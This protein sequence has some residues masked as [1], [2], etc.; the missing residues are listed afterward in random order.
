M[1]GS[2]ETPAMGSIKRFAIKQK[3]AH[4][5]KQNRLPAQLADAHGTEG[6]PVGTRGT[7]HSVINIFAEIRCIFK[8]SQLSHTR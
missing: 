3:L 1:Q 4:K 2:S 7:S 8:Q 6:K 5:Q